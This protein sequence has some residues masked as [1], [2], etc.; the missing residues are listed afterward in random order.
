M[1]WWGT[2][3]QKHI[4]KADARKALAPG[5]CKACVYFYRVYE[6]YRAR[7]CPNCGLGHPVPN[8]AEVKS[9]SWMARNWRPSL[10]LSFTYIIVHTYVFVPLFGLTHVDI[11]PDMWG[12]LK[13]GI[14]G[15]VLGRSGE[16][17]VPDVITAIKG[18][19][20]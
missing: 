13:L 12:L 7:Y 17:I 8:T 14:G 2:H 18:G 19:K 9:E 11:P 15:Y 20:P 4:S 16:K 3:P 10:M 1:S 6:R 5:A